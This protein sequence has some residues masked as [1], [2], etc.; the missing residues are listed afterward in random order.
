MKSVLGQKR[1]P[2]KAAKRHEGNGYELPDEKLQQREKV[3]LIYQDMGVIR[4]FNK[5]EKTL[6]DK[7][8]ELR[9]S[10]PTLEKWSTQHNWTARVQQYDTAQSNAAIARPA[11]S[12]EQDPVEALMG[13]ATKTLARAAA[14]NTAVTRPNEIKSLIDAATNALKLV[15]Q[16]K[17]EQQTVTTAE[18]IGRETERVLGLV[19]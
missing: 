5:L 11:K 12:F 3:Y 18:D 9:V 2:E 13:L 10:R 8:P 4:S 14:A 16:M 7:H 15:A 6:R 17:A 19:E 1:D